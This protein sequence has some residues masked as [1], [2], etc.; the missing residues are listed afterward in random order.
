VRKRWSTKLRNSNANN[1]TF[2]GGGCMNSIVVPS[3][4]RT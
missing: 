1:Q 4:S 2:A 3:P